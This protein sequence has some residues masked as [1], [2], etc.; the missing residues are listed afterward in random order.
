[1]RFAALILLAGALGGC[2]IHTVDTGHRGVKVTFG[3]VEGEALPEGL[4]FV[5]PFTTSIVQIDTRTQRWDG[6]TDAYTMDVQVSHVAFTLNYALRPEAA[7]TVYRTIGADW[8]NK[9]IAQVIYQDLK[10]VVAKWDAVDLIANRQKATDDAQAGIVR[11]LEKRNVLVSGF[12]LNDIS[13]S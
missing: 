1:M 12:F 11:D 7:T 9:L 10:D 8:A 2:G 6:K 4:Y 3:Q 5:N 13:F